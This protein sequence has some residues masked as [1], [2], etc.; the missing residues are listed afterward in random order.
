MTHVDVAQPILAVNDRLA[1]ANRARLDAAGV[2]MVDLMA[3]PG[4]GKTSVILAT[5]A[6][7]GARYRIAVIEGDIASRVDADRVKA[8]GVTA[9]QINT[10]GACHL[11]SAM[12]KRALDVLDLDALD[13]IIVENVGNL[14]CPTEF[15]LGEHAKVMI[16]SLPE[17]DDKPLKY[18]NIFQISRAVILNKVDVAAAFNFDRAAFEDSVRALNPTAPIFALSATAGTGVD[19]W[20]AWLEQLIPAHE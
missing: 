2:V 1:A 17:G 7:L 15:D 19:A 10:G 11:E 5:I 9:V 4:A 20:C 3:S 18:P 16:L 12:I 8:A 13:L 6:A 14:V